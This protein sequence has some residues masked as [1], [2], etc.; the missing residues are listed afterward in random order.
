MICSS[1]STILNYVIGNLIQDGGHVWGV[2]SVRKTEMCELEVKKPELK[3]KSI[4]CSK[5]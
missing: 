3:C 4:Y 2:Y 1:D 5:T